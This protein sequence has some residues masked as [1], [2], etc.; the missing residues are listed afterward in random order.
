M[1]SIL[2]Q[3]LPYR[4]TCEG[5]LF[6]EDKVLARYVNNIDP[7]KKGFLMFPGGGI[8][9]KES[10]EEALRREA[11][12]ETGAVL[13]DNI[14]YLG[15]INYDWD[16]D[17]AKTEKQK[18][19]YMKFRGEEIHFFKGKVIKFV[20]PKGDTSDVWKGSFKD[21]LMDI[22]ETVR[23]INTARPFPEAMKKYLEMQLKQLQI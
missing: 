1:T 22:D 21:R 3:K 5:Y 17:W 7:S 23:L 13:D 4:K 10:P 16:E 8:D 14:E 2:R 19:R 11:L 12:E 18:I 9:E 20:T 6:Y 15:K